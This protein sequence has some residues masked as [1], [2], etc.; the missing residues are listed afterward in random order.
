VIQNQ[1][2]L[3]YVLV[4]FKL[5]P[6]EL[7]II[8]C[9]DACEVIS[10]SKDRQ[11]VY[12]EGEVIQAP[13]TSP[14]I[15]TIATDI[16]NHPTIPTV[17]ELMRLTDGINNKV[18]LE[19]ACN[20]VTRQIKFNTVKRNPKLI[21]NDKKVYWSQQFL[22]EDVILTIYKSKEETFNANFEKFI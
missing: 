6:D 4:Q 1:N 17:E 5:N 14:V 18:S 8:L 3:L 22:N 2:N 15:N 13:L 16:N 21:D 9:G 11:K 7:W 20:M 10:R 12:V 19:S